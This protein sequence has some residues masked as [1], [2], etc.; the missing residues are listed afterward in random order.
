MPKAYWVMVE[1]GG[2]VLA[3]G[4]PAAAY[5]SG[6]ERDIRIVPGVDEG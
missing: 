5:D 2:R 1:H 4:L 6:A 3:R